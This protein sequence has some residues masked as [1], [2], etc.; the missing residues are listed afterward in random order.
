M[1][2]KNNFKIKFSGKNKIIAIKNNKIIGYQ[3]FH[4]PEDAS[5]SRNVELDW[6]YV[7]PK[8]RR[9]GVATKIIEFVL[10][11]FKKVV[12]I[13]FWTGKDIEINKGNSLYK[14]LGFK[15]IAYQEGYYKK[16]IGTRLFVKR[17]R[18]DI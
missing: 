11:N 10:K 13:S 2:S 12:W 14:K 15:E 1:K 8:Y 18:K 7:N 16:D 9:E 4:Y 5:G 3:T 17:V 6:L